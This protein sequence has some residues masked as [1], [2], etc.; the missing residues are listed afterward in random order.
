MEIIQ[1]R[2]ARVLLIADDA[3]LLIQGHDPSRPELGPWWHTPG[4]GIERDEPIAV[5]AAREIAEETGLVLEPAELGACVATRATTFEFEGVTY[6]QEEWFFAAFV[7]RFDPHGAGWEEI[8]RR[9]LLQYRWWTAGE[10]DAT[11]AVVYPAGLGA[12]VRAVLGGPI[13]TPLRLASD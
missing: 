8:E 2:A 3:V 12:V 13:T 11:S 10:L 4:G 5:A 6:Q 9:S 7:D 1:R